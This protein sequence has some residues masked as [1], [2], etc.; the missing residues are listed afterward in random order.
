MEYKLS[1]PELLGNISTLYTVADAMAKARASVGGAGF[2]KSAHAGSFPKFLSVLIEDAKNEKLQ[3][4]DQFG[5]QATP[6]QLVDARRRQGTIIENLNDPN[7]TVA[8]NVYVNLHQLNIWAKERGDV[9][10]ITHEGVPWL[11]E[12]GWFNV[13]GLQPPPL[14]M[15]ERPIEKQECQLRP[16]ETIS[17][18]ALVQPGGVAQTKP[19]QRFAAQDAAI[20]F[21][22][23]KLGYHRLALPKNPA[24][25]AG[26]KSFIRAA[27][28]SNKL[29]C[30]QTI[31]DRAWERLAKSSEIV[32]QR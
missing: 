15:D 2:H 26:P 4:C 8:L 13:E 30:G 1:V 25:K 12:R 28:S 32:I 14:E 16:M 5:L 9:F 10:Q 11:D 7:L 24:G 27:L 19:I 23:E 3:V 18:S 22:I 29:F 31:F 6:S 21:E 20:L 17:E